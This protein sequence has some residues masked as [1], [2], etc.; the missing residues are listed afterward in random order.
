[1]SDEP[2]STDNGGEVSHNDAIAP[3]PVVPM[4]FQPSADPTLPT[5]GRY[6]IITEASRYIIDL[7]LELL[8]RYRGT[9]KPANP[10]VA[11]PARLRDEGRTVRLLRI[12]RLKVGKPAIFDIES[13]GGPR[14]AFTRRS[15][16]FVCEIRKLE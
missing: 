8:T 15:T 11:F 1:M 7:D 10:D 14:I 6:E 9:E 16:T 12:V 3:V 13:L 5:T 4:L 2:G